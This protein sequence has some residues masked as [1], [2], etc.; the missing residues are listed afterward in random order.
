MRQMKIL[1]L[2][3][4]RRLAEELCEYLETKALM[5]QGQKN[6]LPPLPSLGEP[7]RYS[8]H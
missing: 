4:D 5:Q 6:P 8:S 3:D 2:E 1:I 7:V